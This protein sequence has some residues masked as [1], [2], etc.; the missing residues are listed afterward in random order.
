M[1]DPN[2]VFDYL[3]QNGKGKDIEDVEI[4]DDNPFYECL[5]PLM[6]GYVPEFITCKIK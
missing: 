3:H 5:H 2:L 6:D 1:N 4:S